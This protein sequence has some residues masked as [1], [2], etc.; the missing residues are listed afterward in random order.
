MYSEFSKGVMCSTCFTVPSDSLCGAGEVFNET[1]CQCESE[2]NVFEK[3]L[4]TRKDMH[5]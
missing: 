2:N 1:E 3:N 4:C 5:A